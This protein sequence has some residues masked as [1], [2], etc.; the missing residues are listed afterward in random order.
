[1]F[2]SK[3]SGGPLFPL[4]LING[5]SFN[6]IDWNASSHN[7]VIITQNVVGPTNISGRGY[8]SNIV[9]C[10]CFNPANKTGSGADTKLGITLLKRAG[11]ENG[12]QWPMVRKSGHIALEANTKGFVITRIAKADL[13]GIIAPQEGMM[14]Y[15]TTDK[16]LKI[17]ADGVWACFSTP[18][19]P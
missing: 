8:G 12:D 18:A 5:N 16:C 3:V 19:C 7:T 9:P 11:N 14:V 15:D 2:G 17:Y 13:G 10:V 4:E 6:T 1:M